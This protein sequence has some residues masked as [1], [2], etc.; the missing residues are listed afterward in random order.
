MKYVLYSDSLLS[1]LCAVSFA[2]VVSERTISVNVD[3]VTGKN[4]RFFIEVV[5]AGRAAE[6]LRADWQMHLATVHRE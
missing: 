4:S 6:G 1:F 2:Q 3:R 5:G